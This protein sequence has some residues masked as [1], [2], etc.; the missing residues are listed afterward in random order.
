ML[1]KQQIRL[2]KELTLFHVFAIATGTTLSAGFFLLPGLV[3]N[4]SGPAVPLAYLIA[5]LPL[6][7]AMFSIIELSTAMPKA[8]GV[9]YFLDRTLGPLIG[10]IGGFGTWA[11]LGLKVA[12]ALIGMGAYIKLFFPSL[13]IVP[14]AVTIA[15]VLGFISLFGS[16]KS[17]KL[18]VILVSVLLFLLL[19]FIADGVPKINQDHFKDFF[20]SGW[21]NIFAAAGLVYISYVGITKI[22]SLSEE[23]KNPEKN[24]PMGIFLSLGTSVL[25]YVLGTLIMVGVIPLNI[26]EGDLTPVATAGE[27]MLGETGVVLFSIAAL[28]AF[29]SVAN[30]GM[31][32]ASR[33][34]L[35]L[36]RDHLLPR[37]LL[38]MSKWGTPFYSIIVTVGTIV[39]ILIL[40]DPIGIVK[41]A[42]AFQLMV[43]AFIC[44]AVIII[45]ESRIDAYDPGYKSPF[46]PWMQILGMILPFVLI[47]EMGL[48]PLLFS[49]GLILIG[50][51]WYW[52]YGRPKVVRTGAI[53]HLFERMGRLRYDGLDSELR[54]ILKEKGLRE[55]DPFDE[56]VARSLVID[57]ENKEEFEDVVIKASRWISKFVEKSSAEIEKLF[58]EGTRMGATPVTH[59]IALPHIRLDGLVQAEM[60]IVR[61]LNGVHIKFKN[62]LTDFSDDEEDVQA[63][64]FL[65]SPEKDPTQHLRILAQIAGRVEEDTFDEEWKS[66]K[67]EQEIREVLVHEDR[68]LSIIVQA[69]SPSESLMNNLLKDVRFPEGCLVAMLRREGKTIVPTGNTIIKEGDRLTI[70]GEPKGMTELKKLYTEVN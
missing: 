50:A 19:I 35:A 1:N 65:V 8:G 10:T 11:A 16:K 54:G 24:L 40:L 29:V 53:Y 68:L 59:G 69:N 20:N 28:F 3:A 38:K 45:R 25:I 6:I 36:S 47:F 41:L 7:P 63:V 42:S 34:P 33:Y 39:L 48:M 60:V 64:F 9:Y 57:L 56:I 23:V 70:I 46:Y 51:A 14:V 43:F 22:A 27:I 58:L 66:A 18:Q 4:Y 52:I 31:L 2:K 17:G 67:D 26:L 44:L 13:P 21:S 37:Y 5:V 12:F 15:L 62:P 30:G 49:F 61:G 55:A 32:A